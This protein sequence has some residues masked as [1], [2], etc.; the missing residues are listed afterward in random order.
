[1]MPVLLAK[2]Q[3]SQYSFSMFSIFMHRILFSEGCFQATAP[4]NYLCA[5]PVTTYLVVVVVVVVVVAVVAVAAAAAKPR[6]EKFDNNNASIAFI[7]LGVSGLTYR[8]LWC[9]KWCWL[10]SDIFGLHFQTGILFYFTPFYLSDSILYKYS[11]L[12]QHPCIVPKIV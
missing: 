8:W 5:S 7:V 11:N 3:F 9:Y 4:V 6:S 10:L 2:D 1:M 12:T